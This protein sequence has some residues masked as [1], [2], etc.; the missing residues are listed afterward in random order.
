MQFT[1]ILASL[2]L[3][4]SALAVAVPEINEGSLIA[5]NETLTDIEEPDVA[6][7]D[8]TPD[9]AEDGVEPPFD[10]QELTGNEGSVKLD[11]RDL[12]IEESKL[13]SRASPASKIVSC[14]RSYK[15]TKY[16]YG[17]CKST[18]PFGP[19]KG[20][21]DCSCLSRT[22]IKKGTGTTI[23]RTTQTQYPTK[24]GKCRKVARG[25]AKPGDLLFWGC[26]SS[27]GIH[28]VGV[29]SKKGYVTHAPH[30][31]STVREVKI[32]TSG[33]CPSVLRCW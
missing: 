10:P 8:N 17:G 27:S 31:G 24:A 33:I 3:A 32:W 26:G 22:C 11:E 9:V 20:G 28:H 2:L 14:A 12:D 25:S 21:M 1:N 4:S 15:G 13:W 6:N 30:T 29:Y 19:A 16:L 18:A 23:P 5:R 7:F